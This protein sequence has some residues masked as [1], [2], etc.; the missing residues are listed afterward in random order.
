MFLLKYVSSRENY[1]QTP[2]RVKM[3]M[4][5]MN[6]V[7]L[8]PIKQKFKNWRN[9]QQ[10]TICVQLT[11]IGLTAVY[12][13][14]IQFGILFK[15]LWNMLHNGFTKSDSLFSRSV[16]LHE[17]NSSSAQCTLLTVFL[18]TTNNGGNRILLLHQLFKTFL[19]LWQSMLL[20]KGHAMPLQ[21]VNS[22]LLSKCLK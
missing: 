21:K 10:M 2:R 16:L 13:T 17:N 15:M 8:N 7:S 4:H 6:G 1:I 11:K 22:I 20:Q 5:Q 3:Y 14:Y 19:H 9:L 12:Y 18:H